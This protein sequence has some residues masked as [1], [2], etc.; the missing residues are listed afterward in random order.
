MPSCAAVP[1]DKVCSHSFTVRRVASYFRRRPGAAIMLCFHCFHSFIV[2]RV[3]VVFPQTLRCA[4]KSCVSRLA[5]TCKRSA[6]AFGI[7]RAATSVKVSELGRSASLLQESS[8]CRAYCGTPCCLFL[9]P[10]CCNTS[11]FVFVISPCA[12]GRGISP[13]HAV[14]G[15]QGSKRSA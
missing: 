1:D 15:K 14:C 7:S 12:C 4:S 6:R 2:C 5:S 11:C 10:Y 3:C 8:R 13:L 9:L